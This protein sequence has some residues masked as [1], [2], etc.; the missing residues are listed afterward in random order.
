MKE[1]RYKATAYKEN[2]HIVTSPIHFISSGVVNYPEQIKVMP[3][4]ELVKMQERLTAL[5]KLIL[6]GPT[7][8]EAERERSAELM[9]LEKC[10]VE[11]SEHKRQVEEIAKQLWDLKQHKIRHDLIILFESLSAKYERLGALKEIVSKG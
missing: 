8:P 5:E 6:E 4:D 10:Y 9:E 3:Y 2:T 1:A 7:E 11:I